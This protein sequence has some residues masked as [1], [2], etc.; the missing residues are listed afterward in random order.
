MPYKDFL[1]RCGDPLNEEAERCKA[2][3]KKQRKKEFKTVEEDIS[4]SDEDN[5]DAVLILWEQEW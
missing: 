5:D 4:E 1:V 2:E 3:S